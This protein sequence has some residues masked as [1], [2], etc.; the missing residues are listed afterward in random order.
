MIKIKKMYVKDV[1][2]NQFHLLNKPIV[3]RQ[4]KSQVV[5]YTKIKQHVKNVKKDI[6][7]NNLFVLLYNKV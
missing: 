2:M 1:K 4:L 7:K 6:I 3:Q 5:L